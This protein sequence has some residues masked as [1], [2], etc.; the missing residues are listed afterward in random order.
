MAHVDRGLSVPH[1]N[2]PMRRRVMT[3]YFYFVKE[4]LHLDDFVHDCVRVTL[5]QFLGQVELSHDDLFVWTLRKA[6]PEDT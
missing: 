1:L 4:H 6:H 2:G 5:V 3:F